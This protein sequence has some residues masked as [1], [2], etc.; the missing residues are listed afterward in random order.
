MKDNYKLFIIIALTIT[1]GFFALSSFSFWIDEGIRY[2]VSTREG[3]SYFL[4]NA[5]SEKQFLFHCVGRLWI[6]MV[7]TTEI[8]I[9]SLNVFFF[10]VSTLY[11]VFILKRLNI[12]I[13]WGLLVVVHPLFIYYINDYSPYHEL[14]ACITGMLYHAYYAKNRSNWLHVTCSLLWLLLGFAFHFIFGFVG[15]LYLILLAFRIREEKSFLSIRKVAIVSLVLAPL[16]IG[17]FML[18][19]Y[20]MEHGAERGWNMPGI[21]NIAYVLYSFLG[22]QGLG[23]ARNDLRA[24]N[25]DE[26]TVQMSML[27]GAMVIVLLVLSI[28]QYRKIKEIVCSPPF[29]GSMATLVVFIIASCLMHFHYWERHCIWA[30]PV[31]ALGIV[32]IAD[33]AWKSDSV[34]I[35][36]RVSVIF[37]ALLMLTSSARLRYMP[38]YQKDDYKNTCCWVQGYCAQHDCVVLLQGYN[39]CY[40][41][42]K[43]EENLQSLGKD[44]V[45]VSHVGSLNSSQ[46]LT[47]LE[48]ELSDSPSVCLVLSEKNE[49]TRDLYHK[50]VEVLSTI[51]N[52]SV[53]REQHYNTFKIIILNRK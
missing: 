49:N 24:G 30:F 15:L 13:W 12:S 36:N 14:S 45:V 26:L 51:K 19:I 23:L 48:K 16:F 10:A 22:M 6:S 50:P 46:L 53:S 40:R 44:G 21:Q 32:R 37:L 25:M 39:D 27:L 29:I 9:R 20:F 52:A 8:A 35:I 31:V 2:A 33:A 11:I 18:Y 28:L 1:I 3:F 5:S 34:K 7:P 42:Y 4:R 38:Y 17:L 47:L 41:F 43:L